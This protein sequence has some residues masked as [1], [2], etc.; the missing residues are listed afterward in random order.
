LMKIS[1][2]NIFF[3]IIFS[4]KGERKS[5]RCIENVLVRKTIK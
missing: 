4:N 3:E 2:V 1:G 5:Y